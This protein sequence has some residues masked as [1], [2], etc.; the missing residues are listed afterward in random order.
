MSLLVYQG[1]LALSAILPASVAAVA[2]ASLGLS[3]ALPVVTADLAGAV[4]CS[5][6]IAITPPSLSGQIA[7]VG[8]TAVG[9]ALAVTLAVP[10]IDL[11]APE[12]S[13]Q[14]TILAP[15]V[16]DITAGLALTLPMVGLFAEGGVEAWSF[17]GTSSQ[18]GGIVSTA[19]SGGLPDGS[20]PTQT[21]TG[22]ILAST[23]GG[24]WAG[25]QSFF[26]DIPATQPSPSI[27]HFTAT[28]G[29]LVGQLSAGVLDANASLLVQ[30]ASLNA[31]LQG[32]LTFQAQLV[33]NTPTLAGNVSICADLAASLSAYVSADYITPTVAIA[34]V[35]AL[36]AKL[37]ADVAALTAQISALATIT[38]TLATAGVLAFTYTGT[39]ADLG[40]AISSAVGAGWP[41]GTPSSSPSNALILLCSGPGTGAALA[42]LFGGI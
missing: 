34:A 25:M 20:S 39:A 14:V 16:A 37:T 5:T 9:L 10:F 32:A 28:I 38:T 19:V 30:L 29:D 24:T 31:R 42:T 27:E 13:A 23:G 12:L 4:A 11:A 8:V 15:P 36:V 3:D 41:D 35:A 22:F 6:S 17:S 1:K 2:A 7:S 18:L 21:L 33:A 26:P 40:A